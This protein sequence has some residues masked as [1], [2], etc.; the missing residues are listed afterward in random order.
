MKT[1]T[2]IALA[3]FLVGCGVDT[4]EAPRVDHGQDVGAQPDQHLR[5]QAEGCH[6]VQVGRES[7]PASRSC[8]AG[9]GFAC[10]FAVELD[11]GTLGCCTTENVEPANADGWVETWHTCEAP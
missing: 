3:L 10:T 5:S 11:D 9:D 1:L 4:T 6:E 8:A 7:I 2:S